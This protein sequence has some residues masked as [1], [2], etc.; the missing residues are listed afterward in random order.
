LQDR[1]ECVADT[2]C[3]FG[4]YGILFHIDNRIGRITQALQRLFFHLVIH[5][6][7]DGNSRL[8]GKQLYQPFF[9]FRIT[10]DRLFAI[11]IDQAHYLIIQQDW[12][13]DNAAL[14]HFMPV[15]LFFIANIIV[16]VNSFGF[17][18]ID[19]NIFDNTE[20][21]PGQVAFI[22]VTGDFKFQ[23]TGRVF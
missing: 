22:G 13:T 8:V 3:Q 16:K 10:D 7:A 9:N 4:L 5:G 18:G 19:K 17:I 23:P 6:I 21:V 1:V 11:R 15:Q 12:T 14:H 20:R 2:R